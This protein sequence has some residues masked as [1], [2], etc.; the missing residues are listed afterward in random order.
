[1]RTKWLLKPLVGYLVLILLPSLYPSLSS[2]QSTTTVKK[3]TATDSYDRF[4]LLFDVGAPDAVGMSLIGRPLRCLRVALGATTMVS[5]FGIRGGITYV[6]FDY[7]ISPSLSIEGGHVFEASVNRITRTFGVE[8]DVLENFSYSYVNAH[9]GIEL[10]STNGLMFFVHGGV[11]YLA[12]KF[13]SVSSSS[14]EGDTTV[15]I[16]TGSPWLKVFGPSAKIGFV[17]HL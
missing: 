13:G 4:G 11:S 1:M 6:P 2:A 8:S 15:A 7:W 3:Q 9:V 10:G 12:A 5:N 17:Y 14:E 16:D